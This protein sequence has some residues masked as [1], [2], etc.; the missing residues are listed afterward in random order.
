MINSARKTMGSE[1]RALGVTS[2]MSE[3]VCSFRLEDA[4]DEALKVARQAFIDCIGVGVAGITH[5]TSNIMYEYARTMGGIEE[6]SLIGGGF[7][8]S[9]EVAATVNGTLCHVLDYDDTCRTMLAHAS[10]VIV[11]TA[12]SIGQ[13]FGLTGRELLEGYIAGFE[14]AGKLG[15]AFNPGLYDKGWHPTSVIG[16]F[17]GCA[18]ALKMLKVSPEVARMAFGI[19][20]SEASGIKKNFG[21]MTK[22]FHAG[23]AAS[24]AIRATLLAQC[25]FT[26]DADALDGRFGFIDLYK[27]DTPVDSTWITERLGN[28][29]EIISPGITFKPYPCVAATHS[30]IDGA[31]EIRRELSLAPEDVEA[32]ECRLHPRRLPYASREEVN[33]GLQGKFSIRYCVAAALVNGE[34]GLEQ[35][36]DEHVKKKEIQD[37]M[38][39]IQVTPI[40][41]SDPLYGHEYGSRISIVLK[42][43]K[44]YERCNTEAKGSP[45]HPMQDQEFKKKF[46]DCATAGFSV[47]VGT[48]LWDTLS[49]LEELG[50][51]DTLMTILEGPPRLERRQVR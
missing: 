13:K 22:P 30:L 42:S 11:P 12:L 17:G 18:C 21:S 37:L 44:V 19:V 10:V 25:G 27:G 46:M 5:A 1:V 49:H 7:K 15:R 45:R 29:Y 8:S 36:T 33:T 34:V 9:A 50:Q 14:I 2:S 48:L 47:D 3:F 28:P 38:Q 26:S 20:A 4:G 35:F 43:G 40:E 39:R 32:V 51:V 31:L 16:I 24:K 23:S 41:G 6:V